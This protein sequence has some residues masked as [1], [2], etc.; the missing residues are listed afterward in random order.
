MQDQGE[1]ERVYRRLAPPLILV[2]ILVGF[3]IA[4][5]K[6][7]GIPVVLAIAG[8]YLWLRLRGSRKLVSRLD[9]RSTQR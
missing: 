6:L 4:G 3:L 7:I 2:A 8:L 1:F 5:G 9:R